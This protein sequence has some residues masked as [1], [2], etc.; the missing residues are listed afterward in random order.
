MAETTSSPGWYP[1]SSGRIQWWDGATWSGQYADEQPAPAPRPDPGRLARDAVL[2]VLVLVLLGAAQ[3]VWLGRTDRLTPLAVQMIGPLIGVM[4]GVQL[5]A[6]L[7]KRRQPKPRRPL[8][9]VLTQG[10][11][12][13]LWLLFVAGSQGGLTTE[14]VLPTV[15]LTVVGTA[16]MLA[17][18]RATAPEV[19]KT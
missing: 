4:I 1:D 13:L 3:L 11:V 2:G 9:H 15:V 19:W 8:W 5:G 14:V 16:G 12:A 17:L 10:A 6:R 18:T 7:K